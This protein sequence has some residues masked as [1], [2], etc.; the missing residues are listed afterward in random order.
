VRARSIGI[1]IAASCLL[2]S[3]EDRGNPGDDNLLTGAS[4]VVVVLVVLAVVW[5]LRRR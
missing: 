1:V 3:C 4:L 5:F 2:A